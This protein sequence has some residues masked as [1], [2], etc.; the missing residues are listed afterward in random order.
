MSKQ[1][2][3]NSETTEAS[4][5]STTVAFAFMS[6]K[7]MTVDLFGAILSFILDDRFEERLENCRRVSREWRMIIDV[8]G[9]QYTWRIASKVKFGGLLSS[10]YVLD[11]V[12]SREEYLSLQTKR[13]YSVW[14]IQR[15]MVRYTM[16]ADKLRFL[17]SWTPKYINE[18]TDPCIICGVRWSAHSWAGCESKTCPFKSLILPFKDTCRHTR[19]KTLHDTRLFVCKLCGEDEPGKAM[20]YRYCVRKKRRVCFMC[21]K[22]DPRVVHTAVSKKRSLTQSGSNIS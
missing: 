14:V 10:R 6:G 1:N 7:N 3:K 20:R 12:S 18:A 13:D 16:S 9:V 11:G 19:L 21:A 5:S 2:H 22:R 17:T 15:A 4:E 8:S